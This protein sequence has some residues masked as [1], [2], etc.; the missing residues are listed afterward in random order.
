MIRLILDLAITLNRENGFRHCLWNALM[1]KSIGKSTSS[2]VKSVKA[3]VKSGACRRIIKV[4]L[5]KTNGSG[6]K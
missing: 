3:K 6:M 1:K 5:V 2:I 4:K